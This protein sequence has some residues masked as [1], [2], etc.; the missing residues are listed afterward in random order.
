MLNQQGLLNSSLQNQR[1]TASKVS[2]PLNNF[3]FLNIALTFGAVVGESRH[4]V[5]SGSEAQAGGRWLPCS[6][7]G[8]YRSGGSVISGSTGSI[9]SVERSRN[10][11]R[12]LGIASRCSVWA[13]LTWEPE[14]IR[15]S[16]I[17]GLCF[18]L[19]P[20]PRG[21]SLDADLDEEWS[22]AQPCKLLGRDRAVLLCLC[23][24]P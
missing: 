12:S 9:S 2:F 16:S 11:K 19:R 18:P 24:S 13:I 10:V 3:T 8:L 6:F 15:Q 22:E 20:C 7:C 23:R 21:C 4:E 14:A 5:G 1:I 17:N